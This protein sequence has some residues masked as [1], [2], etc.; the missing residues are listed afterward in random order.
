M[1]GF[2]PAIWDNGIASICV[3]FSSTFLFYLLK[4]N[5]KP[6]ALGFISQI[7]LQFKDL[8]GL[9]L[10]LVLFWLHCLFASVTNWSRQLTQTPP[11]T[12]Q[13]LSSKVPLP[14]SNLHLLYF[15]II[16]LPQ[17]RPLYSGFSNNQCVHCIV[18]SQRIKF[19]VS[20]NG[21]SSNLRK[22]PDCFMQPNGH[23]QMQDNHGCFT[24]NPGLICSLNMFLMAN[25]HIFLVCLFLP[26]YNLY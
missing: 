7:I 20:G 10:L 16:F 25:L 1:D 12:M 19:L 6:M 8:P 3:G 26:I 17:M 9:L 4:W 15:L 11:P 14:L 23:S 21:K 2:K 13:L 5:H 18:D 22:P 24:C